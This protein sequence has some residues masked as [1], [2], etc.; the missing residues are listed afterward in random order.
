[1]R[2]VYLIGEPGSGKSTAMRA[3]IELCGWRSTGEVKIPNLRWTEYAGQE[4]KTVAQLGLGGGL[5]P[6]TDRLGMGCQPVAI[7]WLRSVPAALVL[8]EGDRLATDAFF[9]A[10]TEVSHLTVCVMSTTPEAAAE[11]RAARG[12]TQSET[13]L[14]GRRTKV[15][16]LV[17]AWCAVEV[18]GAMELADILCASL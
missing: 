13:W 5:F 14:K 11:R 3:A 6:G 15:A 17:S 12:T 4:G 10:A 18:R 2:T 9:R 16:R 8:G 1:M 7:D